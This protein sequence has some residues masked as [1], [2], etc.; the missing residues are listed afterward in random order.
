MLSSETCRNLFSFV[1]SIV[2][3]DDLA[4]LCS[5]ASLKHSDG[6]CG[7]H[8]YMGLTTKGLKYNQSINQ[9]L[10][11]SL[12]QS[13]CLFL[14]RFVRVSHIK[15]IWHDRTC[16][17]VW[18]MQRSQPWQPGLWDQHGANLGPTGSSWAPYC[19]HEPCYLGSLWYQVSKN[20]RNRN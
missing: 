4:L 16:A 12:N 9:S 18:G 8:I 14:R 15:T 20:I 13:K 10:N 5:R 2:P 11:Q 7:S 6:K 3:A 1:V 19:P 17:L